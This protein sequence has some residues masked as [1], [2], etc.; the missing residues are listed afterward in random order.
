[1][2]A[3]KKKELA[4]LKAQL[5]GVMKTREKHRASK[6]KF[7]EEQAIRNMPWNDIERI[8]DMN[9]RIRLSDIKSDVKK[10]KDTKLPKEARKFDLAEADV[11][12]YNR[13]IAEM[14]GR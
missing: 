1:M 10:I 14:E 12:E 6:E 2:D 5:R 13:R 9:E 8:S 3:D 4:K 11:R 7:D